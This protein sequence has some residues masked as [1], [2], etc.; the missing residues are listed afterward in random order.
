M[1]DWITCPT[2]NGSGQTMEKTMKDG[3]WTVNTPPCP[4]CVDGLIPSP[5][6]V[7]RVAKVLVD[8]PITKTRS[9]QTVALEVLRVTR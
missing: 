9:P 3:V 2:C 4:D 7:E 8:N 1:I 6:L 5:E